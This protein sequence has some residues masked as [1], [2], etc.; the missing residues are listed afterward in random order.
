MRAEDTLPL[1]ARAKRR[2]RIRHSRGRLV[3]AATTFSTR[4]ASPMEDV[5][6]VFK[7]VTH[8]SK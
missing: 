1:P 8:Y 6:R 4:R 7:A 5:S 2:K 3:A